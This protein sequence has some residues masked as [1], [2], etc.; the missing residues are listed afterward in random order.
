MIN[1]EQ[2]F[3]E[4][5]MADDSS[6]TKLRPGDRILVQYTINSTENRS[7]VKI[8]ANNAACLLPCDECS[9]YKENYYR[10]I[11]KSALFYYFNLLPEGE[12]RFE[13]LFF[14]TQEGSFSSSVSIVESIFNPA[15]RGN[16]E[17]FVI[18]SG[19]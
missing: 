6:S 10:E 11:G 12:S 17:N 5:K 4:L 9:G 3:S 19:K 2:V 14:V 18:K 15:F 13:E 8:S 1:G 7:Y 16:S